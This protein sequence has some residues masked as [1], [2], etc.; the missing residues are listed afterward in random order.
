MVRIATLNYQACERVVTNLRERDLVEVQAM[1]GCSAEHGV[2]LA[3]QIYGQFEQSGVCGFQVCADGE[4]VM[5][6]TAIR[7]T[8]VSV[9]VAA[10]ATDR[11]K[12]VAIVA[13]RHLLRTVIP[14]L[15]AE[16]ITRAEC[17]CLQSHD[18]SIRWMKILGAVEE[19]V[20]PLYGIG[21]QN[22]VQLAWRP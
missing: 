13:T 17:R 8:P 4:P 10:L 5:I 9:Q 20:I 1:T 7:E 18:D 11:F 3:Q 16:G 21:G 14:G 15:K 22:F 12:E 19:C 2:L 6:F